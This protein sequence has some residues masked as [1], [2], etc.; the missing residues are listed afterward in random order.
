MS[1]LAIKSE[2]IAFV[3]M[4]PI[5]S[6]LEYQLLSKPWLFYDVGIYNGIAT[7]H[8]VNFTEVKGF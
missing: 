3:P 5:D 4:N 1:L 6:S 8:Y 2:R 7:C